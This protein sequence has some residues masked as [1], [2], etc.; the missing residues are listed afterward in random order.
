MRARGGG[1]LRMGAAAITLP[2]PK[3]SPKSSKEQDNDDDDTASDGVGFGCQHRMIAF[4]KNRG[5]GQIWFRFRILCA[6][7]GSIVF[8]LG[9]WNLEQYDCAFN[10]DA[11]NCTQDSSLDP[12]NPN[13]PPVHTPL[14]TD[15]TWAHRMGGSAGT[16]DSAGI[17]PGHLPHRALRGEITMVAG[18]ALLVVSDTIYSNAGLEGGLFP[19]C[20]VAKK[21]TASRVLTACRIMLGLLGSTAAWSGSY[22]VL[23][24]SA[25]GSSWSFCDHTGP[26]TYTDYCP[27]DMWIH[28]AVFVAGLIGLYITGTYN[29]MTFFYPDDEEL[30]KA[31]FLQRLFLFHDVADASTMST[32]DHVRYTIRATLSIFSQS[33]LWFSTTR[34]FDFTTPE[35]DDRVYRPLFY[36]CLGA[37]MLSLTDSFVANAFYAEDPLGN[38]EFDKHMPHVTSTSTASVILF[39]TSSF[40]SLCGQ[41]IFQYGVWTTLD[42]FVVGTATAGVEMG[43]ITQYRTTELNI[44]L[45]VVGIAMLLISGALMTNAG[46]TL[47]PTGRSSVT[48]DLSGVGGTDE[49]EVQEMLKRI[50]IPPMQSPDST[51][52]A[53]R[54]VHHYH[55][56]DAVE[57]EYGLAGGGS[58]FKATIVA[59]GVGG[60]DD[61][62]PG[63][64]VEYECDGSVDFIPYD[65]EKGVGHTGKGE[66]QAQQR[67]AKVKAAMA[68]RNRLRRLLRQVR[69]HNRGSRWVH[70]P[71]SMSANEAT[72]D[73]EEAL[74]EISLSDKSDRSGEGIQKRHTQS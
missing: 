34:A 8:W 41:L 67:W 54:G 45:I 24:K 58:D 36:A 48:E 1:G 66:I 35:H 20:H 15:H 56:G 19:A 12:N 9:A 13:A 38:P 47:T 50:V 71:N 49:Q 17:R 61:K 18:F 7:F 26:V 14:D 28:V 31:N 10:I 25:L 32:F 6:M 43:R 3:S 51:S 74:Y 68:E 73:E 30:S 42:V 57:I 63:I 44:M 40:V 39:Y 59:I 69:R 52:T 65:P 27:L 4:F 70:D 60:A 16:A 46:I 5:V 37:L 33:L 55:I 2:D 72:D 64:T 22:N 53:S 62:T 29:S 21:T 23:Q 11:V